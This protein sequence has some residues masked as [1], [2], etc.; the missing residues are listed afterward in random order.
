MTFR[1]QLTGVSGEPFLHPETF[2]RRDDAD[3]T[4]RFF[5]ALDMKAEVLDDDGTAD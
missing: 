1:L 3:R 5:R 4:A 2:E